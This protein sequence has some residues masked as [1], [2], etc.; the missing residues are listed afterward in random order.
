MVSQSRC[1]LPH[2]LPYFPTTRIENESGTIGP[3]PPRPPAVGVAAAGPVFRRDQKNVIRFGIERH[4][5]RANHCCDILLH[6]KAR[7]TALFDNCK[8]AIG[9]RAERF[10]RF[11][12]EARA[13]SAHADG[14]S[15]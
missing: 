15:W 9:L 7:R 13:I 14:K 10:H 11:R 6:G 2:D 5:L 3:R 4:G 1:L 8:R 12:I